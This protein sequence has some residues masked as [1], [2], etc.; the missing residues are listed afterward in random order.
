MS[1]VGRRRP[2]ADGLGQ[3]ADGPQEPAV[4]GLGLQGEFRSAQHAV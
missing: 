3:A 2:W 4:P 1:H